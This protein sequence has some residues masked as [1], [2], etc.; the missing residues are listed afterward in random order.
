MT[1]LFMRFAGLFGPVC[2]AKYSTRNV[3]ENSLAPL[4]EALYILRAASRGRRREPL[5]SVV[6]F[7]DNSLDTSP[8]RRRLSGCRALR[9]ASLSRE[10]RKRE[11]GA[12]QNP[13]SSIECCEPSFPEAKCGTG[14]TGLNSSAL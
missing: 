14:E 9:F 7:G 3:S 8:V 12:N 4:Q 1:G 10:N 5:K 13:L 6:Q 11:S 2:C